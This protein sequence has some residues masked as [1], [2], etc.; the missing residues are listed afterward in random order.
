ME[1]ATAKVKVA[2]VVSGAISLGSFEAGVVTELLRAAQDPQSPISI[3]IIGGASAGA[4]T[5]ATLAYYLTRRTRPGGPTAEYP[6][7]AAWR[8]ITVQALTDYAPDDTGLLSRA[9]LLAQVRQVLEQPAPPRPDLQGNDVLL[10]MTLTSLHG[11]PVQVPYAGPAAGVSVGVRYRNYSESVYFRVP[12][13]RGDQQWGAERIALDAPAGD[14]DLPEPTPADQ[15]DRRLWS[16]IFN[17]SLTSA[18]NALAWPARRHYCFNNRPDIWWPSG[19]RLTEQ[20]RARAQRLHRPVGESYLY[21]TD[22]GTV[23]NRPILKMLEHAVGLRRLLAQVPDLRLGDPG[24]ARQ[25]ADSHYLDTPLDPERLLLFVEPDPAEIDQVEDRE[26]EQGQDY[27]Q[28]APFLAGALRALKPRSRPGPDYTDL[29]YVS[30][31]NCALAGVIADTAG[32]AELLLAYRQQGEPYPDELAA[33]ALAVPPELQAAVDAFFADWV[34]GNRFNQAAL[35]RVHARDTDPAATG[36][37]PLRGISEPMGRLQAAYARLPAGDEGRVRSAMAASLEQH[38]L[39]GRRWIYIDRI[40]PTDPGRQPLARSLGH[41]GGFIDSAWMDYDYLLGRQTALD[42]LLHSFDCQGLPEWTAWRQ[43]AAALADQLCAAEPPPADLERMRQE[44]SQP[45][46]RLLN[47]HCA[48]VQ[49]LIRQGDQ[50]IADYARANPD[51]TAAGLAAR[52]YP[53][54]VSIVTRLFLPRPLLGELL[55]LS[56]MTVLLVCGGWVLYHLGWR[57]WVGVAAAG[58]GAVGLTWLLLRNGLRDLLLRWWQ[59]LARRG[60]RRR[61]A[62]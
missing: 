52:I 12:A 29:E 54:A 21:F 44:S 60:E 7:L 18:A 3:D 10:F 55:I 24:V 11:R 53:T 9:A 39:A 6:A 13:L 15:G 50:I 30:D 34:E 36:R 40:A 38:G 51:N 56:L 58:V 62:A 26:E 27:D 25:I 46:R 47:R 48:A 28:Y 59:H 43:R 32:T 33:L 2:L 1:Q 8:N 14:P 5:G 20:S 49:N 16:K 37:R 41:F 17:Y 19:H 61:P 22:G 45:L 23:D 42:W 31:V 4:V 57:A 35:H